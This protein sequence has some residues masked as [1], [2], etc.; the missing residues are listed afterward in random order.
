MS[1]LLKT[2]ARWPLMT[3]AL[4]AVALTASIPAIAQAETPAQETIDAFFAALEAKDF[5]ALGETMSDDVITILPMTQS[6]ETGRDA[7]R[8]FE[9]KEMTLG[10]FGQAGQAI[11]T[12]A[13]TGT[14]ITLNADET[15]AVIENRGDMVLTDGR[16]YRNLYIWGLEL[17]DGTIT[18][19]REYTNPITAAF[20][21]GFPLP[22]APSN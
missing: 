16:E 12:V 7:M 11:E 4:M 9:G 15:R 3:A 13:F 17:E 19:I 8:V 21:F 6:G 5:S 20:A 18:E 22:D 10:Y 1:P 2:N 14:V